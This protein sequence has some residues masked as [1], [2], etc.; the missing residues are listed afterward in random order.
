MYVYNHRF[1]DIIELSGSGLGFLTSSTVSPGTVVYKHP[2]VVEC[3]YSWRTGRGALSDL[4][5]SSPSQT[6]DGFGI[7]LPSQKGNLIERLVDRKRYYEEV[8]RAAFPAETATGAQSVNRVSRADSGHLFTTVKGVAFPLIAD[9]HL[10][11]RSQTYDGAVMS[12]PLSLFNAT[13]RTMSLSTTSF[14]MTTGAQR[15]DMFNQVFQAM[16][17]NRPDGAIFVA[18]MELLRGDIPSMIGHLK[19]FTSISGRSIKD[20]KDAASAVGGEYLNSVFGW[21]PLVKEIQGIINVLISIDRMVYAESYSRKRRWQGPATS[22]EVAFTNRLMTLSPGGS[23]PGSSITR[24][25]NQSVGATVTYSGT[26]RLTLSEDYRLSSQVS[27]LARPN[28]RTIG[29]VE[30]AEEILQRLGFV[31][32]LA[33]VWELVPYS[34]LVDWVSN[35]GASLHNANVYSPVSGKYTVDY[36]YVTTV[37]THSRVETVR[38]ASLGN[39]SSDDYFS[40]RTGQSFLSS[41]SKNRDRATPF[42][43]GTQLGSLTTSQ[44]AILV[45]LGLA[46]L[47]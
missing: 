15:Q 28:S 35:I 23:W 45:A 36:A 26:E 16:T 25:G 8:Q 40:L 21:A 1:N 41:V 34:W 44:F 5:S 32:S 7:V 42:G 6:R 33:E 14:S 20:Y 3:V 30:K 11:Y 47:R 18:L 46:K 31:T 12:N 38:S 10:T 37:T 17:P 27:S 13:G 19:K 2:K 4:G 29:F 22:S 9:V 39:S 24:T 43:F